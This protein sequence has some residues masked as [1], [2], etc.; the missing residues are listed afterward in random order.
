MNRPTLTVFVGLPGC[1]KSTRAEELLT[2]AARAGRRAVWMNRDRLRDTLSTP[3][4]YQRPET[5]DAVTLVQRAGIRELLGAGWDVIVDDTNLRPE[6]VGWFQNIAA[7]LGAQFALVD[8]SG[9]PVEVCV[10]RDAARP[11]RGFPPQRWA[12]ARVGEQVIRGMHAEH[13]RQ[14]APR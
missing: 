2:A 6:V 1:G 9:V 14:G 7:A 8:M 11:D 5:E 13:L 3:G 10:Q 12:G 4:T